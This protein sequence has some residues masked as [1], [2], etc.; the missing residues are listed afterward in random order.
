M[1]V[2]PDPAQLGASADLITL[3]QALPSC[4][5]RP[6][7]RYPQLW[8]LLVAILAILS[9][10]GSLVGMERFAKAQASPQA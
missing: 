8:M 4:R 7:M 6:G 3:L 9:G 5:M 10:Q 1:P 2:S